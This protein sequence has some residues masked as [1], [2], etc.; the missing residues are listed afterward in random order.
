MRFPDLDFSG[1][2]RH[3]KHLVADHRNF[4]EIIFYISATC[5]SPYTSCSEDSKFLL[6]A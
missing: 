5:R 3:R 6:C 4:Q 2:L 1:R